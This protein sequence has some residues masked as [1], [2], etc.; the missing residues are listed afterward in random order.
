MTKAALRPE[1]NEYAPYY[2]KYVSLVPEGDVV[3]TLG[4]QLDETLALLRS[5]PEERAGDRYEEGKWSVKELIGH[6]I[7]TER[8]FT[9]RALRFARN[10]ATPLQGFEQDDYVPVSGH[11]ARTLS[12][13]ADELEHVR[14][15]TIALFAGLDAEAWTRGGVASNAEVTV[16]AL[17]YIT[18]GH[19]RHHLA[20]L[21]SR[22]LNG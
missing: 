7:D 16:R 4:E 9:Y 10:D 13:L 22:Y 6:V 19:E 3:A 1:S 2:A 15:A 11:D 12:S 14:R 20:I 21:R 18:A 5:I 17:A 8:I